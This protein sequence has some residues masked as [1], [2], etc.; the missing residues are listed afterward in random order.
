MRPLRKIG[1]LLSGLVAVPVLIVLGAELAALGENERALRE[2]YDRYLDAVLT[3][4]NQHIWAVTNDWAEDLEARLATA[5][6]PEAALAALLAERPT[7]RAAFVADT[8]GQGLRVVSAAAAAPIRPAA[9]G[10]GAVQPGPLLTDRAADYRRLVPVPLAGGGTGTVALA[11]VTE[12]GGG[13]PLLAGFVFDSGPFITVEL[14]AKLREAAQ[15]HFVVGIAATS[16]DG[17]V[18]HAFAPTSLGPELSDPAGLLAGSD[19]Q[20]RP[21]W[22]L[23]DHTLRIRPAQATIGEIQTD[24]FQRSLLLLGLLVAALA[25]GALLLFRTVRRQMELAQAKAVFVQNVSHE[26]RTPLALIRMYAETLE[27]GRVPEARRQAYVQTIAQEAGRLTRLVN[28]I[29]NFSRIERGRKERAAAPFALG[30]VA[31]EA[32]RLYRFQLD[33]EGFT[34]ETDFADGL[35][36]ALGDREATGEA[37]VNLID[38]AIKYGGAGR[39]LGLATGRS[40]D[41]VWVAVTDR[42]PGIP[43]REQAKVFD[44]FY[45]V[46]TGAV[47]DVKGTGLG[48]ALVKHLAETQ[49]GAVTVESPPGR[50]STFRLTLPAAPAAAPAAPR[51]EANAVPHA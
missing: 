26:L 3:S 24:R 46:P 14:D 23:P 17:E 44:E 20:E 13:P 48:L 41:R 28:N 6:E 11:V 43:R 8:S 10:V 37:L 39:Y 21:L 1:L 18:V 49:G 5:G 47:H 40:G 16:A 7:L 42:G 15:E 4:V 36:A 25:G 2:V 31:E 51:P 30:A 38:N 9:L 22:V 12:A 33:A 50:G 34:V 35:P 29:L 32:L 27:M 45:R 19:V